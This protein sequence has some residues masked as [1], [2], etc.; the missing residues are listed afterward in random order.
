MLP[1]LLC[2]CTNPPAPVPPLDKASWSEINL[3]VKDLD[4]V[5]R[6]IDQQPTAPVV[7]DQF[8]PTI[9]EAI[10]SWASQQFTGRRHCRLGRLYHVENA[11]VT[12]VGPPGSDVHKYT[13]HVE[14]GFEARGH[15]GEALAAAN[16][17]RT[18]TLPRT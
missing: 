6:G 17:T 2:A 8:S 16:A 15:E 10:H 5:D 7:T 14:V 12:E 1:L 9:A 13:G 3:D 4:F 18:V 11:Y